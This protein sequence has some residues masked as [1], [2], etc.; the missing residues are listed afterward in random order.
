M[1]FKEM[2]YER[3]D[4]QALKEEMASLVQA[5]TEAKTYAEAKEAFLAWYALERRMMTMSS[6]SHIR[7][8]IDTR[9]EFYNAETEFWNQTGPELQEYMLRWQVSL[10]ESSF[11]DDFAR[12]YGEL[13]F[14]KIELARRAFSPEIIEE[15]Q[16]E[17]AL[18]TEYMK[19]IA[20]AQ[21][22]FEGGTYT[23]SQLTPLKKDADDARRLAAWKAEGQWYKENQA[24]L[25][26]IYDEL[27]SLRD[28]M[29]KKLGFPGYTEMGYC[30]M[31]RTCYDKTDIEKFRAAVREHLVPDADAIYSTQAERFGVEYPLSYADA[32]LEFRSGN[33]QPEGSAQDILDAGQ[34]FYRALSPE[35]AVFFDKMLEDELMDVE[36]TEGKE[37]GGYCTGLP[38]YN[39]PF[40]FAN[41]NGTQGDVE[42]VTHEAGHAFAF[43][44]NA[45]RVP[46]DAVWPG[47]E[48]AEVHSMSMEFFAW[49]WAEEFFGKDTRKFLYSH[50]AG[51]LQ[52]IPYGTLVD[53]FQHVVYEKPEMSPAERHAA[54]K[55]LQQVYMP[56]IRL[57]GDIPF[58]A[59]GEAW[60]RQNHIYN[61]P[62][63]YID[64]CL[65]QTVALVFW[66]LIDE[67]R[68]K[69]WEKYMTFAKQGGSMHFRDLLATA[70]LPSPFDEETLRSVCDRAARFLKDYDRSG[71]S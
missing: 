25:D 69:A 2:K 39:M 13:M 51:A 63:Y 20:S 36:S 18:T 31:E 35:T 45:D 7:H 12:E 34:R 55:E 50:L 1:K 61:T 16:K 14:T 30:R 40:I 24:E 32:A 38:D 46:L 64:Y 6:L 8:T 28:T 4:A 62:F 27:V 53:H 54:W 68:E 65:A 71:I 56:W 44:L 23:L 29:G 60:Q 47:M 21:V 3:P 11:R 37:S 41:F 58:Y 42:V 5:L 9:D 66:A 59:D 17:N 43:Y 10:A 15:S 33:P 48:S 49:P 22:P 57:D 26:R 52:F 19:R 70:G 67:D